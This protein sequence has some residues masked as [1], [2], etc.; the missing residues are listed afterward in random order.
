MPGLRS[1][2][3]IVAVR[4]VIVTFLFLVCLAV[5]VSGCDGDGTEAA[6]C[7][8]DAF[9]PVLSDAYDDPDANLRVVEARVERCRNGY[10]QVFAVPDQSACEPGVGGCFE[11][12]QVFFREIDGEWE[13]VTSGTGIS[14]DD[15]DLEPDLADA[16]AAL[17]E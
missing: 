6:S 13:I 4:P 14:C 11:T 2:R 7:E 9:V 3:T 15:V 8:P 17:E 10:A 12:E 5:A 16:C 1:R